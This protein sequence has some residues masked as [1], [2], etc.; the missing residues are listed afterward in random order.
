MLDIRLSVVKA[1]LITRPTL[2][3]PNLG[4]VSYKAAFSSDKLYSGLISNI[5]CN[6]WVLS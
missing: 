3:V 1:L 2:S 5:Y 6:L 4:H